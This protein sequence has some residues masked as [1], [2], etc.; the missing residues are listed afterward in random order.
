VNVWGGAYFAGIKRPWREAK[1]KLPYTALEV[2]VSEGVEPK[3]HFSICLRSVRR[4]DSA[5]FLWKCSV[6][7]SC[8]NVMTFSTVISRAMNTNARVLYSVNFEEW[9]W[10]I[11][12]ISNSVRSKK[13]S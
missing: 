7:R 8:L 6:M 9:Q 2:E 11:P 13:L 1:H 5:C 12:E 4:G 10:E 3:L